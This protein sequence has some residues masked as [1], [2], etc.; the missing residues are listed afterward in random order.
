MC[1]LFFITI[2]LT[3]CA[4]TYRLVH[5]DLKGA[6]PKVEYLEKVN[7]PDMK[8]K[9]CSTSP[10][11]LSVLLHIFLCGTKREREN[12]ANLICECMYN[13]KSPHRKRWS[14]VGIK[15]KTEEDFTCLSQ[16]LACA[17][18]PL[19]GHCLCVCVWI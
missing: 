17:P 19:V 3:L 11:I 18:S 1:L 2:T 12:V 13:Y 16:S 9:F 6:P 5:L 4:Y 14:G 7:M 8:E 15:L 10:L